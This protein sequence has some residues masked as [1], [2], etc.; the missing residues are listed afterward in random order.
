MQGSA[1]RYTAV[2]EGQDID[3]VLFCNPATTSGRTNMTVRLS[4][5]EADTWAY[6]KQVYSGGSAYSD[7]VVLPDWNIGCFY[8]KDSYSKI[9]LARFSL[10]WVT[11]GADMLDFCSSPIAGDVNEDCIVNLK[12]FA[13]MAANWQRCNLIPQKACP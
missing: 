2:D 13:L 12:D 11:D 9:V 4:Y 7:L 8:E 5:D 1:I 6:S 10:E 3:R